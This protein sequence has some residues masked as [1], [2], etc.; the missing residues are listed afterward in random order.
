M[1]SVGERIRAGQFGLLGAVCILG[2]EWGLEPPEVEP[3]GAFVRQPAESAKAVSRGV[4][5]V[6]T[7][8]ESRTGPRLFS[9]VLS[10]DERSR[11]RAPTLSAALGR[12]QVPLAV[13][14]DAWTWLPAELLAADA[15]YT[16]L[17]A[18]GLAE[19]FVT[20]SDEIALGR[21][22]PEAARAGLAAVYCAEQPTAATAAGLREV[23]AASTQV[24]GPVRLSEVPHLPDC[25]VATLTNP[26]SA[27]LWSGH[28]AW[29]VFE[30]TWLAGAPATA[31]DATWA[32]A[33]P[34]CANG[35]AFVVGCARVADD[36]IEIQGPTQASLWVVTGDA[37]GAL[38][39]E[40]GG[41]GVI[42]G[43]PPNRAVELQ[44]TVYADVSASVSASYRLQTATAQ[45]HVVITEV[46]ANPIGTE[47]AQEWVEIYNDGTARVDLGGWSFG[48]SER[49]Q[50]LPAVLLEP[51]AYL[52]LVN[53]TFD[54][55]AAPEIVPDANVPLLRLSE[56]AKG[57]ISNAGEVLHLSDKLGMVSSR[58]PSMPAKAA[59]T[60]VARRAPWD[61]DD[62]LTF[63]E[64]EPPGSS[65][66]AKN[67]VQNSQLSLR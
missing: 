38:W 13:G 22:W 2:C 32:N 16:W 34:A 55:S 36:R 57:G 27:T 45:P 56:L 53:E 33:T 61:S 17:D 3:V 8:Q 30:P 66:G 10:E 21:V 35:E 65:P 40:P 28:F 60:S 44:V 67:R 7:A 58:F 46:M 51:G 4:Y 39:L 48:D 26:T 19:T 43:L 64:H 5:W 49:E 1:K 15:E 47:P 63:G 18:S 41:R 11:A 9:G 24:D 62:A 52:V 59:G 12:R 50:L 29:A 42:P 37:Q 14:S 6:D 23:V 25:L 54:E 20:R 31:V